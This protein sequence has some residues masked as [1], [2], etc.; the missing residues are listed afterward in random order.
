M[1]NLDQVD[2]NTAKEVLMLLLYS[3]KE[4]QNKVPK[5]I[6]DKLTTLASQSNITVDINNKDQIEED[7]SGEALDLFSIIYYSYIA[8]EN[9]KKEILSSWINNEQIN[10]EG[11]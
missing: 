8:D 10:I 11:D 5:K 2:S 7:I 9:Q 1:M 4:T 3:E 6:I